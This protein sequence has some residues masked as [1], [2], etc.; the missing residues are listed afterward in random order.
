MNPFK[1]SHHGATGSVSAGQAVADTR[2]QL[3]GKTNGNTTLAEHAK[4]K[5]Q[6]K[7]EPDN[8]TATINSRT[9]NQS[10]ETR[11]KRRSWFGV[12]DK[13]SRHGSSLSITAASV[14]TDDVYKQHKKQP[15]RSAS[16]DTTTKSHDSY[17]QL[18]I[19]T[20]QNRAPRQDVRPSPV[21]SPTS[22]GDGGADGAGA[23][24]GN[25]IPSATESPRPNT[26]EHSTHSVKSPQTTPNSASHTGGGGVRDSVMKRFS[27]LRG[28]GRKSS[29]LDFRDADGMVHEE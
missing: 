26:G 22:A 28:V 2:Q 27:L 7:G 17:S 9:T 4:V 1:R 23:G 12:G 20:Q 19:Q 29:R 25:T 16:R 13:P 10:H 5:E 15:S 11:S 14:S 24:N 21:T 3:E 8:E 18:A 6:Q